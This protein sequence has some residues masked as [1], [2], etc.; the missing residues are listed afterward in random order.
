MNV[1]KRPREE[2]ENEYENPTKKRRLYPRRKLK[3]KD[4]DF[5]P[6]HKPSH[7][8]EKVHKLFVEYFKSQTESEWQQLQFMILGYPRSV[9]KL[10]QLLEKKFR[11]EKGLDN[12]YEIENLL[13]T[14]IKKL[15]KMHEVKEMIRKKIDGKLRKYMGYLKDKGIVEQNPDWYDDAQEI[16]EKEYRRISKKRKKSKTFKEFFE[17]DREDT[18]RYLERLRS[19]N[20]VKK[21][22]KKKKRIKRTKRDRNVVIRF[23]RNVLF[24]NNNNNNTKDEVIITRSKLDLSNVSIDKLINSRQKPIRRRRTRRKKTNEDEDED[25]YFELPAPAKKNHQFLY[26]DLSTS[27]KYTYPGHESFPNIEMSLEFCLRKSFSKNMCDLTNIINFVLPNIGIRT[28]YNS[29]KDPESR[30]L[31]CKDKK[32]DEVI[33]GIIFKNHFVFVEII[34]MGVS[35]DKQYGGVGSA[36]LNCLKTLVPSH[37]HSIYA[38]SD[39]RCIKFYKKNGFLENPITP[40]RFINNIVFISTDS[41]PMECRREYGGFRPRTF[42]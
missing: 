34:L 38:K 29:I 18:L 17:K 1:K 36:M 27:I 23:N 7:V 2:D 4:F 25:E 16:L 42:L 37:I 10:G 12:P 15:A 40:K 11:D 22:K 13:K 31:I 20:M 30:I 35:E 19:E 21:K 26:K 41:T 39:N 24:A 8:D 9:S 32:R 33:G 5:A 14:P 3:I 6:P 28:I